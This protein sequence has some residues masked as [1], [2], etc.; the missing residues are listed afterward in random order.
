LKA[1]PAKLTKLLWQV[2]QSAVVVMWLLGF[3][4]GVTPVKDCR[5]WHVVQPEL[6]PVWFIVVLGPNAVVLL[7]QVEQSSVVGTWFAGLP[8][9][10]PAP[11]WQVAQTEVMPE[12]LKVA[13]AKLTKL[14]WQVTQSAEVAMW[15]EGFE[16]GVTPEKLLPLWQVV[17]PE[18]IPV[19]FMAVLGPKVVVLLWQVEQSSAVGMC[20]AGL[21]TTP[22]A[23]VWQV[24]QPD[25]MPV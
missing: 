22:P 10:P 19:W 14:L 11:V 24:A 21:P 18:V 7:W 23:P 13:P 9:T 1:A 12:W 8:T 3:E 2:E 16:T 25:V 5:L 15:V 20:V 17:Q 6:M 4:T